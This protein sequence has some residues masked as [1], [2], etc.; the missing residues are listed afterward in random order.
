MVLLAVLALAVMAVGVDRPATAWAALAVAA[1]V[2]VSVIG[3]AVERTR[4][5][6][7]RYEEELAAWAAERA[8]QTERL[9]IAADLHDLVSHG[10]GLITVRAAVARRM[11]SPDGEAERAA[12]LTDIERVSRETTTELRRLL[13]VLR[14]PGTAPLRPADTLEDLLT[15]V[16]DASTTGLTATLG[17]EELGEVSPGVQL[18]I[19][20]VVREALHNTIRH[21]GPTDA[22]IGVRRDG[23]SIVVDVQDAGPRGP[24]QQ[25]PGAGHGLDGLRERVIALGGTLNAE[26]D[27]HGFHVTARIPDRERP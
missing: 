24:W 25:Q 15:I 26:P 23:E 6:C 18:T 5:Q 14:D 27:E 11:S 19:C 9:R 16:Q 17:I 12:A 21:A 4:R 7:R 8:T 22:R 2:A 13:T 10:L 20:A 3:W 1:A